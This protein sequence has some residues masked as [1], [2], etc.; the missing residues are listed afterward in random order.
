MK[1]DY[2]VRAEKF[3]HNFYEWFVD[4]YGVGMW[5]DLGII[6]DAVDTYNEIY[7]RKIKVFNGAVRVTLVTSDY[8]VK[9][10]Y[11]TE[12]D[13][14]IYG[15]CEQEAENYETIVAG[16]RYEH[17][18]AKVTRV[19]EGNMMFIIMP[20][21]GRVEYTSKTRELYECIPKCEWMWIQ[22]RFGD[23]HRGNW[24]LKNG[25]PIITDYAN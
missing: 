6:Y 15:G 19:Y 2:T 20:R 17:Y 16:S 12:E 5:D 22:K 23:L 1:S 25:H 14:E 10:D 3:I 13:I 18:F 11:G 9:W 4:N 21:I 7:N 24:G 8:V